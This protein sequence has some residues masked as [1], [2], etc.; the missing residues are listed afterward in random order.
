MGGK[1]KGT[2]LAETCYAQNV[3]CNLASVY[4]SK[5]FRVQQLFIIHN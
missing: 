4:L 1:G 2:L 3:D 5:S